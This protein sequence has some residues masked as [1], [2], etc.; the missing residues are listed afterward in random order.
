MDIPF[1]IDAT[2]SDP[3]H[4]QVYEALRGAILAGRLRS[5]ERLPPTRALAGEL[6]VSRSTVAEAYDQL[7]S[8]GYIQGRQGSGTYVAPDLPDDA[9]P[10]ASRER[11][12]SRHEARLPLSGLARKLA[13]PEHAAHPVAPGETFRYDFRPHR[14]AHDLF[15][16]NDWQASVDRALAADRHHLLDYP[17]TAGHPDLREA[18]AAHVRRYRAVD[19]T[20]EQV[21]VVNGTLQGLNLLAQVLLDAGD[22]V[23]VE[24]PGYPA[25]RLAL[26]SRGMAVSH[27]PVDSD[28]VIVD[29]L[30]GAGPQRLI[31]VTPSHQAPTGATL[32]LSRR[33]ALLE[34]AERCGCVIVEDDYDS[35]FRYEGRPVESLQGLDRHG[36]VVYAGTFSK[37][38]LAG[39]RIGFLVLPAPLLGPFIVA[40]SLWDGGTPMLEQ[41]ALAQFIGSGAFER[42]IRRMRRMYRRRR[43]ALITALDE[44]L[45]RRAIVG[46][47]HG[48]LNL[49]LTLDITMPA[50]EIAGRAA[51][52]GI[53]L[54]IASG[55]YT[56]PPALPTFLLGFAAL[57]ESE[58]QTGITC[59]AGLL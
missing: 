46:V 54:R 17:P 9:L 56:T 49:L 2:S 43:D 40:K 22:R 8:E 14:I 51:K 19:C 18:I 35:E 4:R 11:R 34:Y 3:R 37:S 12:E 16:W 20:P 26:A 50:E 28:G 32:S 53:G 10:V 27:L 57:P 5:G 31:H 7:Q 52:A 23:A 21:V 41:A 59:L 47:R 45:G 6:S 30:E 24:D 15:P 29:A 39:L 38:L 36:L 33:L 25:A 1:A 42:H 44:S 48:G 55:Y 58:I 13:E